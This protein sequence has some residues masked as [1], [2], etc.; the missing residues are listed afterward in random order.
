M[1][2]IVILLL[3]LIISDKQCKSECLTTF[4]LGLY[5]I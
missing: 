1:C 4:H 2:I 3:T 5:I